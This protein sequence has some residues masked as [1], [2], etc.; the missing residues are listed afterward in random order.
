VSPVSIVIVLVGVAVLGAVAVVLAG[1][2][3]GQAE[4]APD[5]ASLELPA[6]DELAVTDVEALRFSVGFRGYRMDQVD[7]V[8]DRMSA[9]LGDR[10]R[11]IAELEAEKAWLADADAAPEPPAVDQLIEGRPQPTDD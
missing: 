6:A 5:R 8:L 9:A 4:F 11:R 7:E 1:R 10:D 3:G 2:T